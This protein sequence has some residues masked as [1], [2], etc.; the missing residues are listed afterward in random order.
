MMQSSR[1]TLLSSR[2]FL[3]TPTGRCG[4][5]ALLAAIISSLVSG[6]G[7][8]VIL[9]RLP[10]MMAEEG[11][12]SQIHA[13]C[14]LDDELPPSN[15]A[16][17][18]GETGRMSRRHW[19]E[20]G[21]AAIVSTAGAITAFPG[22]SRA[23]ETSRSSAADPLAKLD[24]FAASL[25]GISDSSGYPNTISPLPTLQE[26]NLGLVNSQENKK[27]SSPANGGTGSAAG[28]LSDFQK[29]LRDSQNRK[30]IDPRTHG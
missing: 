8:W 14:Q 16:P 24:E 27:F 1:P 7:A 3:S 22:A 19:L 30:Q 5:V 12:E 28:G 29:A 25:N 13:S 6:A 23:D 26:T 18:T 21:S 2:S 9:P 10:M 11:N 4:F 15:R 17:R 20:Q